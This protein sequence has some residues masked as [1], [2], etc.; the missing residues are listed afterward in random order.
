MADYL[1]HDSVKTIA[2][3]GTGTDRRKLG[4]VFFSHKAY[5]VVAWDPA[6][7]DGRKRL[8]NFIAAAA[9]AGRRRSDRHHRP[10]RCAALRR[11]T[12]RGQWQTKQK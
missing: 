7:G 6:P 3:L 9:T 5:D 11:N 10:Q 12:G 1:P 2:V 4:D 8:E